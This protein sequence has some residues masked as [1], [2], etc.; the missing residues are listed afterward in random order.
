MSKALVRAEIRR[1]ILDSSSR[2]S[3]ARSR[4]G[5]ATRVSSVAS[6]RQ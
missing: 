3:H 4:Y 1:A 5:R 2:R 6:G